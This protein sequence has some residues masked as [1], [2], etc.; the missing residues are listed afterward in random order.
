MF[1]EIISL[2]ADDQF[3]LRFYPTP[4]SDCRFNRP[5][6]FTTLESFLILR[7]TIA[8]SELLIALLVAS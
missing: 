4:L 8:E 1:S 3:E 2:A 6:L 7:H 5:R